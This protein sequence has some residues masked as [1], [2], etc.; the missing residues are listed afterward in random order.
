MVVELDAQIM[1]L[2]RE[3]KEAEIRAGGIKSEWLTQEQREERQKS[4]EG[5]I[6]AEREK[7]PQF[8]SSE[9]GDG[10]YEAVPGGEAKKRKR[11]VKSVEPVKNGAST[12]PVLR[13]G[14]TSCSPI[15][16]VLS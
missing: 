15:S 8:S 4:Q 3:L 12:G 5:A 13:P 11:E 9:E 1:G 10:I 2:K 16:L 14:S 6:K 7:D